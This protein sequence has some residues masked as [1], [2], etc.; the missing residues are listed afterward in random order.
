MNIKFYFSNYQEILVSFLCDSLRNKKRDIFVPYVILIQSTGMG[1][2][3]KLEISKRL[4]ITCN[5]EFYF[6]GQLYNEIIGLNF[7]NWKDFTHIKEIMILKIMEILP[8]LLNNPEFC[9]VKNYLSDRAYYDIK[10]YQL[11][12]KIATLFDRYF[13]YRYEMINQWNN[14]NFVILE[15]KNRNIDEFKWQFILWQELKKDINFIDPVSFYY[16]FFN[17]KSLKLLEKFKNIYIFG[18]SVIP[19]Y[20][21]L[22]LKRLSEFVDIEFYLM[23]PA[24]EYYWGDIVEKKKRINL[25]VNY[26]ESLNELLAVFGKS[27][28]S[29]FDFIIDNFGN[30]E[31]VRITKFSNNNTLLSN[32]QK[33]ISTLSENEKPEKLCDDSIQIHKCYNRLREVEALYNFL[34][35]IF[36][37]NEDINLE[38]VLVM[39]PQIEEYAPFIDA[40]FQRESPVKLSYHISDRVEFNKSPVIQ[41]FFHILDILKGRFEASQ[42]LEL[43]DFEIIRNRFEIGFDNIVVLKKWIN[44]LN[45]RWGKDSKMRKDMGF[46]LYD[47]SSWKKG[48]TRLILGYAFNDTNPDNVFGYSSYLIDESQS[49]LAGKLAMIYIFLE[50]YSDICKEKFTLNNWSTKILSII[51]DFFGDYLNEGGIL[52]K[53]LDMFNKFY[54]DFEIKG[55]YCFDSVYLFLKD[56][57][58]MASSV[59]NFLKG[60]IT[61]SSLMPMRSIPAK[62]IAVLGLDSD[63]FPRKDYELAF[64]IMRAFPKRGDRSRN[65]SDRY[66]FLETI[67]SSRKYLF[68]SYVSFDQTKNTEKGSSIVLDELRYY[69]EKNFYSEDENIIDH[70]T[71]NHRLHGFS[72]IYFEDSNKYFSYQEE[73]LGILRSLIGDYY[74]DIRNFKME[75]SLS[76]IDIN[77]LLD[78]FYDPIN[79]FLKNQININLNNRAILIKDSDFFPI[80]GLDEYNIKKLLLDEIVNNKKNYIVEKD[81]IYPGFLGKVYLE[82]IKSEIFPVIEGIKGIKRN[83]IY[84]DKHL[85]NYRLYGNLDYYLSKKGIFILDYGVYSLKI[86]R[87]VF[88]FIKHLLLC[89]VGIEGDRY[90]LLES[91]NVLY[92]NIPPNKAKEIIDMFILNIFSEGIK[93]PISLYDIEIYRLLN[94][95][96]K[97][98]KKVLKSA[99][100][101]DYNDMSIKREILFGDSYD[102]NEFIKFSSIIY[103][104][105]VDLCVIID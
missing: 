82:K 28:R 30:S 14:G 65:D 102:F 10:L 76:E 78:F 71:Y 51:K 98:Y 68:L 19:E 31:E 100:F 72:R 23:N 42:I 40:V 77:N 60:G 52:F 25:K 22:F 67:L 12:E 94:K 75:V 96:N 33:H 44:D 58:S 88:N 5:F 66:L 101:K 89:M 17:L 97:K 9:D 35:D 90:L 55:R 73:A 104:Y 85:L 13:I 54:Y 37:K 99:Y 43:F 50:K 7:G 74:K 61:V 3:L 53:A 29:F 91:K 93:R 105:L 8:G 48:I 36:N 21:I 86:N 34:L 4:G 1:R 57:F 80:Y 56:Y 63:S 11:S 69:I 103:D 41:A 46:C 24:P 47:H 84:I 95:E 49:I 87:I 6:P 18:V 2:W 45:I 38:D 83:S 20:Y 59:D 81:Y 16:D 32:I 15:A 62:V 27:G 92:R 70:I 39:C 64:D 79:Y 26:S